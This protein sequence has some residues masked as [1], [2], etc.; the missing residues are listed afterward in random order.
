MVWQSPRA[1]VGPTPGSRKIKG[2]LRHWRERQE[3]GGARAKAEGVVRDLL[4]SYGAAVPDAPV[5]PAAEELSQPQVAALQSF[6]QLLQGFTTPTP[7]TPAPPVPPTSAEPSPARRK[8]LYVDL[9]A[10]EMD[11]IMA[12]DAAGLLDL[13]DEDMGSRAASSAGAAEGDVEHQAMIARELAAVT[14]L[15]DAGWWDE[16]A[17]A[18]AKKARTDASPVPPPPPPPLEATPWHRL[19]V[20]EVWAST[21]EDPELSG[22]QPQLVLR[23]CV[24]EREEAR[25]VL[26][27][28]EW[29]TPEHPVE[30]GTVV[31]LIGEFDAHG[32]AV[33]DRQH[34]YL[35]VHPDKLIRVTSI[36]GQCERRAV[37]EEKLKVRSDAAELV[38]GS[39]VHAIFE[40][41]LV[42]GDF[43]DVAAQEHLH[44]ELTRSRE[45]LYAV[46]A[47][48]ADA[49]ARVWQAMPRLRVWA[50]RF[51]RP[52][53]PPH[54]QVAKFERN[55]RTPLRICKVL[56][57]E[58]SVWSPVWG[59]TGKVDVVVEVR[60][61]RGVFGERNVTLFALAGRV[62]RWAAVCRAPGAQDGHID[63]ARV[64]LAHSPRPGDV[65]H[66]AA[67]GALPTPRGV[68]A[69][70]VYAQR[71]NGGRA[72]A[73]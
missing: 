65:V 55:L 13:D 56:E 1:A 29:I 33:V 63:A 64:W 42:H 20:L 61:Q 8:A 32:T 47:T 46:G 3:V 37:L 2:F 26:L 66:T 52:G 40:Q 59:L 18:S 27:R 71:A 39:V 34:N 19:L 25:F 6:V 4:S 11:A 50:D 45:R 7:A 57:V 28:R 48:E 15:M 5:A 31:H 17:A 14:A 38:F 60:G 10:R 16:G 9:V 54:E 21:F 49:E 43:G 72:G 73:A 22:P 30:P 41:C 62:G 35:V 69:A 24:H 36:G 44:A 67:A 68:G 23:C 58:Q 70:A 51:L 53:A 12:L